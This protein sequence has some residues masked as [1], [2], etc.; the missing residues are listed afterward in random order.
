L[1]VSFS[2]GN[3]FAPQAAGTRFTLREL[4]SRP[5]QD[6]GERADAAREDGR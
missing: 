6:P 2:R 5:G 4:L 1:D 3:V